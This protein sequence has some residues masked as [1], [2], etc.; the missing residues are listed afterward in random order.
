MIKR[1]STGGD[2][3]VMFD[4]KRSTS[5]ANVID[6]RLN[7]NSNN[8]E[9]SGDKMDFLS[10]GFKCIGTTND[11]NGSGDTYTYMSFAENPFTTSSGVPATAR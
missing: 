9:Q 10:N 7:P 5:G 2:D 11:M 6:K 8:A 1:S 4:N 3:W